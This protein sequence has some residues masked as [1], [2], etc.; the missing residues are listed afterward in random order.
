MPSAK[1]PLSYILPIRQLSADDTGELGAYLRWLGA[2]CELIIVDASPPAVFDAH[3]REWRSFAVHVPVDADVTCI[4]G[5]VRGVLTG[6][7]LASFERIVIADDDIRYD[8]R[9]LDEVVAALDDADVVRPQNYFDPMPWHAVIDTGRILLNRAL[10]GDWPGTLAVRRSAIRATA[11]YSG[12]VLF[13]N[14]E[15]V[16]TVVAAGGTRLVMRGV[17]VRRLPPTAAH[18]LDQR[19]RQAYDEFAR[20]LRLATQ[21]AIV[22]AVAAALLTSHFA[23]CAGAVCAI[24]AL[25]EFGRRRS[26]GRRVFPVAASVLAPLWVIERGVCAWLAVW[27][28]V[29]HGGVSYAGRVVS[30]AATPMRELR[31]R[32]AGAITVT[33][34]GLNEPLF[35]NSAEHA[36]TPTIIGIS[37]RNSR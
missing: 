25:A 29:R 12:D 19:V 33:S 16:R 30:A 7:R 11:G 35:D 6:F 28:R 34:I 18:F 26:G 3:A 9:S 15:L 5:K 2:H 14:L 31:T 10:D 17:L 1:N 36:V 20:P 23:V 8:D 32:H 21:L 27:R 22:P 24:I 4:N 37:A 13:E